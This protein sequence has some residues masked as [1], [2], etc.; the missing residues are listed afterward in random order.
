MTVIGRYMNRYDVTL[1]INPT[2]RIK[3][4][5]SSFQWKLSPNFSLPKRF[6]R[7]LF[8]LLQSYWNFNVDKWKCF[9]ASSCKDPNITKT[10]VN[11]FIVNL[12]EIEVQKNRFFLFIT[13]SKDWKRIKEDWKVGRTEEGYVTKYFLK[14]FW[15]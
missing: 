12:P 15:V 3:A 4:S 8:N 6:I 14:G 11:N 1:L 13:K 5:G 10:Y 9:A 7:G 2:N